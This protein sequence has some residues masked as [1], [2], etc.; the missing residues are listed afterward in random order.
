MTLDESLSVLVK[1]LKHP[2]LRSL[3]K[4]LH[5]S[6]VDGSSLSQAMRQFPRIFSPLYVN[7]V[8]AGEAS[9]SLPTILRR[10]TLHIGDVKALR[11]RVQ[12]ALLYPSSSWSS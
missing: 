3:S 7:M 5:Q 11:D 9:G 10:L 8:S 6:L 1:R 4:S 2:K 12:Q